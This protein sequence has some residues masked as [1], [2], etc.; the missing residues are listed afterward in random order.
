[1]NDNDI[2]RF[3]KQKGKTIKSKG[4]GWKNEWEVKKWLKNER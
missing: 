3:V 4:Y 2:H 1:M